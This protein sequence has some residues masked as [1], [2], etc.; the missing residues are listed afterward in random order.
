M[1]MMKRGVVQIVQVRYF[2]QVKKEHFDSMSKEDMMEMNN[3]NK[4]T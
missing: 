3:E 1:I 4:Q 2:N